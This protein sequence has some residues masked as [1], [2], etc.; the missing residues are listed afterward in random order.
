MLMSSLSLLE[1]LVEIYKDIL[2]SVQVCDG[3]GNG[4]RRGLFDLGGP[5]NWVVNDSWVIECS[6]LM[7]PRVEIG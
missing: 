5:N 2:V 3:R 1:S 6:T 4:E 7:Y